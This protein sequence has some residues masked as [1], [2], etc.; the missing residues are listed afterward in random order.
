MSVVLPTL[1]GEEPEN[2]D[3]A[4]RYRLQEAYVALPGKRFS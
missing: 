4:S 2:Q 1:Y 3:I